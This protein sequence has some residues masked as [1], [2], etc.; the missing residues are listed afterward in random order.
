MIR[1]T[2]GAA[3]I[4]SGIIVAVVPIAVPKI[5]R[6]SGKRT[7]IRITNGNERKTS[8]IRLKTKLK[9]ALGVIPYLFVTFKRTPSGNP[10][11]I[12]NTVEKNTIKSVSSVDV[13]TNSKI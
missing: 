2:K 9:P 3:A 4:E 8:M 11:K 12:A 10:I 13:P 5:K 7:I 6:V 1:A